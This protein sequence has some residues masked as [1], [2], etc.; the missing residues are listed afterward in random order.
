MQDRVTLPGLIAAGL[1]VVLIVVLIVIG[2]TAPSLGPGGTNGGPASSATPLFTPPGVSG[3]A[4]PGTPRAGSAGASRSG[5]SASGTQGGV[6]LTAGPT[7]A[8]TPT[9]T[10]PVS[11]PPTPNCVQLITPCPHPTPH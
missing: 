9:P 2:R 6:T 3:V 4:T 10:T 8:A 5:P 1:M 7:R 11:A